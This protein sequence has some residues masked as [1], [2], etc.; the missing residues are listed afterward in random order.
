VAG[1]GLK[2]PLN[3]LPH[4]LNELPKDKIIVTACPHKD[5]AIIAMVYL[6][7]RRGEMAHNT[8]SLFDEL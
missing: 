7:T 2:I 4:R 8:N 3:Q 5:R 6:L 1:F